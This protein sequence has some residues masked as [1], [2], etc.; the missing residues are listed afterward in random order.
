MPQLTRQRGQQCDSEG[1]GAK[2]EHS[3]EVY[4]TL[5]CGFFLVS[6]EHLQ[7]LLQVPDVEQFAQVVT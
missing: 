7:L 6:P 3:P 5:T 4:A 1:G 2:P